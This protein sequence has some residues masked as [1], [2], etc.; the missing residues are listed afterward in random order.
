MPSCR[1]AR[2]KLGSESLQLHSQTGERDWPLSDVSA[3]T[4]PPQPRLL[5]FVAAGTGGAGK[6]IQREVFEV[7]HVPHIAELVHYVVVRVDQNNRLR[8]WVGATR[9]SIVPPA[10][11]TPAR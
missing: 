1:R 7:P 2:L 8:G 3:G 10:T 11:A 9:A 5:L 4:P 6:A